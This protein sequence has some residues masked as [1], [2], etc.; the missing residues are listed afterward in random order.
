MIR[1]D[2]SNVLLNFLDLA[3]QE[4]L[5]FLGQIVQVKLDFLFLWYDLLVRVRF[6]AGASIARTIS[7]ACAL[8]AL[9]SGLI[10]SVA[11]ALR[12]LLSM[13]VKADEISQ[14]HTDVALR[15]L[16]F[17]LLLAWQVCDIRVDLGSF[18]HCLVK[19]CQEVLIWSLKFR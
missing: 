8:S 11:I 9:D 5:V 17:G 1:L 6:W 10:F 14:V 12:V 3:N 16:R 15:V 4:E 18:E 7:W 2:I 13:V 19:W